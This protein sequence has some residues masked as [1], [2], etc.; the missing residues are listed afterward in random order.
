MNNKELKIFL[1]ISK[2]SAR[3][4]E[5]TSETNVRTKELTKIF[6]QLKEMLEESEK[7]S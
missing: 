2:T 1:K 7:H 6:K 3:P 4:A 5:V